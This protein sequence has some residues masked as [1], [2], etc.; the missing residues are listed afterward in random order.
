MFINLNLSYVQKNGKFNKLCVTA[1]IFKKAS[2]Y[3][4]FPNKRNDKKKCT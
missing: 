2:K 4:V 1:K 3:T